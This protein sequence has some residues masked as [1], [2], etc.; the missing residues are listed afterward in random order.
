MEYGSNAKANTGVALGAVGVFVGRIFNQCTAV[1]V[2]H[3]RLLA[4]AAPEMGTENGG[5]A[6]DHCNKQH[7]DG[8]LLAGAFALAGR[9][10]RLVA[11]L[12]R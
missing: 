7:K 10:R 12:G 5:K 2:G 11:P 1:A 3:S 9:L 6:H 8:N 4:V